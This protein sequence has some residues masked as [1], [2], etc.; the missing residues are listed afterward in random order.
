MEDLCDGYGIDKSSVSRQW[1]SASA[2]QL[3][4]MMER[5]LE[6]LDICVLMLDGKEFHD[7]TLITALGI[8]SAGHKRVLGLWPGATENSEVCGALLDDL[9]ERGLSRQKQYLFVIDGSK[10]LKKGI[11]DRFGTSM[12]VQRC[13]LHKERNLRRY[14]P[15][16]YHRLVAMKLKAAFG[17]TDYAEAVGELRKVQDWLGSINQ[18]AAQ[19]LEEG[20]E[21]LLTVNKLQLPASLKKVFANT[22]LIES[23]FSVADDLCRNVKR[24]R[25]A[26]MAWRWGGTVLLE[27]EKRF[28]RIKGYREL[29]LLL[30]QLQQLI[31]TR[32]AVA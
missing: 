6:E 7:Y 22:N 12:L 14:L 13:R 4:A 10:A 32:E 3:A 25:D 17:M 2:R 26:N 23:C 31:D 24:W 15:K 1:Q 11:T 20:F 21:E 19:S 9:L 27:A 18:A 5:R 8:D 30:T 29:P 16:K 28:R